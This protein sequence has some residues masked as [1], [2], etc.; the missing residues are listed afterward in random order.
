[1]ASSV[2]ISSPA[3]RAVEQPFASAGLLWSGRILTALV[4]LFR[5]FDGVA[6]VMKVSSVLAASARL[7][8]S[9][10]LVATGVTPPSSTILDGIPRTSILVAMLLSAVSAAPSQSNGAS[11]IRASAKRCS[12]FILACRCGLD[13]ISPKARLRALVPLRS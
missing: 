5:L 1:M 6:K 9:E 2:P 8:L 4:A 10:N 13:C 11:E 3:A 7:G 12:R